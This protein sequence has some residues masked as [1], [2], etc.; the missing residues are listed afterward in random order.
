MWIYRYVFRGFGV[1]LVAGML[2]ALW[3]AV[4]SQTHPPAA[5]PHSRPAER[6]SHR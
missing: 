6:T 2:T 1:V 3:L 4:S 5:P